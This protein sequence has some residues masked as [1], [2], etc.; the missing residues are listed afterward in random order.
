M[1]EQPRLDVLGL[2][3]LA[4][5]RVGQ[6]VDLADGQVVGGPPLDSGARRFDRMDPE[7]A[8]V[9]DGPLPDIG[10]PTS[11]VVL[12]DAHTVVGDRQP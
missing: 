2:Q 3:R 5:Q 12:A 11:L 1:A 4:Q 8:A 9:A 6:Q 7:F 10:Q